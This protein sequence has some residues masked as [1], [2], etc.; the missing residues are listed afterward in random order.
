MKLLL[1]E[2]VARDFRHLLTEHEVFTVVYMGWSGTKNGRLLSLAAAEGFEEIIT[3][4]SGI[5]HQQNPNKLPLAVV[6]LHARSNDLDDL[7]PVVPNLLAALGSLSP[8]AVIHVDGE[9]W[10]E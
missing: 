9:S 4:D 5:E 10:K 7:L 3:T 8:R 1:D 2:C 6:I